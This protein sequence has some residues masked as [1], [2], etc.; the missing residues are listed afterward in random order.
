MIASEHEIEP[1]SRRIALETNSISDSYDDQNVVVG[2]NRH[3]HQQTLENHESFLVCPGKHPVKV[4]AEDI[5]SV[6]IRVVLSNSI[7]RRL[8]TGAKKN[9]GEIFLYIHD[10]T[11]KLKREEKNSR[12]NYDNRNHH[13]HN[14]TK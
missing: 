11:E 4:S 6:S 7:I 2:R 13:Q 9:N 12:N 1:H 14:Q 3:H 5:G 8:L 10:M